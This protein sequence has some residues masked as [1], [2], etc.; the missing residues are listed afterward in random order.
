MPTRQ[1]IACSLSKKPKCLLLLPPR[2]VAPR[3]TPLSPGITKGRV[4]GP[5]IARSIVPSFCSC[6]LML[7][8]PYEP[9]IA[10]ADS[11]VGLKIDF[12]ASVYPYASQIKQKGGALRSGAASWTTSRVAPVSVQV[13]EYGRWAG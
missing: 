10:H 1:A 5:C 8:S 2:C 7:F 3:T 6:V 4:I 9:D 13:A 11:A 12:S